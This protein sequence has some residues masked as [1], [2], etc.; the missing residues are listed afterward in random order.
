MVVFLISF[1][2]FEFYGGIQVSF[3]LNNYLEIL[4]D[5]YYYEVFA[6]TFG[7]ALAVT[8]ACVVLGTAEAYV[9]S[10]MRNP[11][12][13]LFLMVVLGPLLISVAMALY[14]LALFCML[15]HTEN[16]ALSLSSGGAAA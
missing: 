6:R 4:T 13:G 3:S 1:F 14:G 8:L 15:A 9:L 2:N 5:S 11:W 7:V 10:R 12:K 16:R